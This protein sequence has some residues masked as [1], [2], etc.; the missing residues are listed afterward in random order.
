VTESNRNRN[1][2]SKSDAEAVHADGES[3]VPE[4]VARVAREDARVVIPN[5]AREKV[6]T[7]RERVE[8]VVESGEAV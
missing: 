7:A 1:S 6:R 5:Q 8:E 3:L 4:D 2:A